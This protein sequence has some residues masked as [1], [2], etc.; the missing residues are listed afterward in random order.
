MCRG[1][2]RFHS[3]LLSLPALTGPVECS[4]AQVAL[5]M[6]SSTN[7]PNSSH[8]SIE[9]AVH[10]TSQAPSDSYLESPNS[11]DLDAHSTPSSQVNVAVDDEIGDSKN[12]WRARSRKS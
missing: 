7:A 4:M 1:T 5:R 8:V 3:K 11:L 6:K 2:L 12:C 10:K 9:G